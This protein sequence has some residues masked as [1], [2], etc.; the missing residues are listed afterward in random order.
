MWGEDEA[1]LAQTQLFQRV[2][3]ITVHQHIGAGFGEGFGIGVVRD[4]IVCLIGKYNKSTSSI[5]LCCIRFIF[6]LQPEYFIEVIG[7]CI[8]FEQYIGVKY[9]D[10]V[11]FYG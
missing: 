7:Y 5:N 6:F 9:Q 10:T 2:R 4:Q 8:Q 3:T 1:L 11:K